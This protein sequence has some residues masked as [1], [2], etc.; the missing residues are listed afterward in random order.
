MRTSHR[1]PLSVA[2][3]LSLGVALLVA[4]SGT[5]SP[6]NAAAATMTNGCAVSARGIPSC[7][8]FVGAAYG[9]NSDL[10][11]WEKSMGKAIGVHR[12]YWSSGSVSSAVKS[13]TADAASTA[14]RG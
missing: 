9:S 5:A 6:S 2:L 10:A 3:F 8:A 7:G 14:F 1:R 4:L 12:T 13:A 11:P